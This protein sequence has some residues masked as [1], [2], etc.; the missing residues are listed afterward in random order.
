[1]LDDRAPR[2][3]GRTKWNYW[4]LRNFALEGITSFT[5]MP[6]KVATYLGLAV[7]LCAA[8]YLCVMIGKNCLFGNRSP[9]TPQPDG[10][11]PS[12]PP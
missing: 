11:R 4:K 10:H 6:L 5:A 3:A 9:A 2:A 7:G 1:M 12:N 8:V